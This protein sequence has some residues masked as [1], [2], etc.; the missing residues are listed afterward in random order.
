MTRDEDTARSAAKP[1]MLIRRALLDDLPAVQRLLAEASRWLRSRG[2]DQWP[3][4]FP[5]DRLQP[6]VERGETYLLWDDLTP[7]G[8]LTLDEVGDPE[9]WEPHP[10][11]D[12]L[13]IHKMAVAR[14]RAGQGIGALLLAWSADEALNRDRRW[15]RWDAWKSNQDLQAYYRRLGGKHLR[16]VD[17]AHRSSGALF[18]LAAKPMSTSMRTQLRTEYLVSQ[19]YAAQHPSPLSEPRDDL[20]HD[21]PPTWTPRPALRIRSADSGEVKFVLVSDRIYRFH[22]RR[23]GSW[24]VDSARRED[25]AWE[26]EGA[27]KSRTSPTLCATDGLTHLRLSSSAEYQLRES[28]PGQWCLYSLTGDV[29]TQQEISDR[30][31]EDPEL[32]EAFARLDRAQPPGL[33]P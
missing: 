26:P 30:L 24:S 1:G 20:D 7:V 13:Y 12:A 16:T 3:T 19:I 28:N 29:Q 31:D 27:V 17:L 11:D 10:P 8:T 21:G 4:P 2:I 5:I 23:D 14:S 32:L 15:L 9:F 18:Q 22:Y 33:A 25:H 6:S